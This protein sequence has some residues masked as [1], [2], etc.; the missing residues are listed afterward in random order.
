MPVE[1]QGARVAA[2]SMDSITLLD[3]RGRLV[4]R[5]DFTPMHKSPQGIVANTAAA[6]YSPDMVARAKRDGILVG[7]GFA[8]I[9]SGRLFTAAWGTDDK[10]VV[11]SA[12]TA[13]GPGQTNMVGKYTRKVQHAIA[14]DLDADGHSEVMYA[15]S[16]SWNELRVYTRDGQPLWQRAFGPARANS[17][18]FRAFDCSDIDG[19]GKQEVLA[20]L[21]DGWVYAFKHDG[22][23]AWSR[24]VDWPVSAVVGVPGQGVAVGTTTGY[25]LILS[26]SGDP[27]RTARV[28]GEV[29]TMLRGA[30]TGALAVG[31]ATGV[32]AEFSL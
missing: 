27:V 8:A 5:R 28:R 3:G 20:G 12:F 7:A 19:D 21:E 30:R 31:T 25:I 15:L 22:A 16:G 29:T 6:S 18:F 17:S 4:S 23:L 9:S 1:G 26:P 10:I 24:R 11:S 2:V 32:V 13:L 14:A